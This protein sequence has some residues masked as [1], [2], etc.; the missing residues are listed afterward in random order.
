MPGAGLQNTQRLQHD[1]LA[2]LEIGH[3]GAVQGVLVDQ[4]CRLK[5]MIGREHGV[6]MPAQ[7]DLQRRLWALAQAHRAAQRALAKLAGVRSVGERRHLNAFHLRVQIREQGDQA[8]AHGV[9]ALDVEA[10]GVD[11]GQGDQ[12]V[13]HRGLL[14]GDALQ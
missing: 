6:Q 14:V 2:A 13:P 5:R 4:A 1:Q 3:A 10:A 8:F 7:E 11:V 12:L 9:D